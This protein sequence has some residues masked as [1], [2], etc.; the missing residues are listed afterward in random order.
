[1]SFKDNTGTANQYQ[2]NCIEEDGDQNLIIGTDG[3]G[4]AIHNR[5]SAIPGL[6]TRKRTASCLATTFESFST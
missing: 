3:G 6:P 5:S 4:M 2:I 1:M